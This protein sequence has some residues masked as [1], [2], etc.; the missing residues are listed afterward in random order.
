[1]EE[2]KLNYED[3][4]RK[5]TSDTH[6]QNG[7]PPYVY[8]KKVAEHLLNGKNII[9]SVP[10]GAGKTWA[11]IMPFL[12]AKNRTDINFPKKMIYSLPL[13]A[14]CNSISEDVNKAIE[15]TN[16]EGLSA[17]QTG[18]FS[19]DKYFE[20]DIIFSTIDQTLSNFLCFPLPLSQ[21]QANV[22][23]GALIGSYLVFDEFHLLDGDRSM[24]TTLGMLRMLGKLSRFCIMTATLSDDF[25]TKI[26][27][28][29]DDIEIVT[30]DGFDE[31]IAKI[32]SL[33]VPEN[34][35]S[36][37]EIEV[38]KGIIRAEKIKE[39][40]IDKTIVICNRVE[41]AQRVY[42]ELE[43][44]AKEK[45]INLIC[46][47][48]RFFDRHRKAAEKQLKVL[49]GKDVKDQKTNSILISTQVIEAGMDISCEVMHTEIAPINAL[50]QRLGRCARYTGEYGK[51]FV[52][53][54]LEEEEKAKID[55]KDF[56]NLSKED[57]TEIRKLKNLY[58]PYKKDLCIKTLEY[59]SQKK[60]QQLNEDITIE[61]VN[62][63]LK[64]E[65]KEIWEA[66]SDGYKMKEI[67][68]SW[69]TSV[70]KKFGAKNLYRELIRD[71]QSTEV[72]IID[73]RDFAVKMPFSLESVGIFKW[74]VIK[75]IKEIFE[76]YQHRFD[77]E[78]DT[79]WIVGVIRDKEDLF[80]DLDE[81]E[82]EYEFHP[83]KDIEAVKETHETLFLNKELFH[84]HH[85]IGFN[86]VGKGE[87]KSNFKDRQ[88]KEQ[89]I[90]AYR[91]DTFI[92]HTEGLLGAFEQ[93]FSKKKQFGKQQLDFVFNAFNERL[94]S[95]VDFEKLIQL[96]LILHDYG[97]LDDK[98]QNW[99]QTYQKALSEFE[100][101]PFTYQKNLTLGHTG[102]DSKEQ[103]EQLGE[104]YQNIIK[105]VEKSIKKK[106]KGGR[107]RH[108]GVG[109]LVIFDVLE[110]WLGS[111][112][113]WEKL[114]VPAA[115]A[116]ARHHGV[117][118]VSSPKF[119]VSD[120]NYQSINHL[121]EK[122]GFGNYNLSQKEKAEELED[123]TS[124]S[125]SSFL[126]YLFFVRILRLCDQKATDD[127]EKYLN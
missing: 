66:I 64:Q 120:H 27:G 42:L 9:L 94:K 35:S 73:N 12:Y 11:S 68:D 99:M 41:T 107:P 33:K 121:L 89:V 16:F 114:F 2:K 36:K 124:Y 61:L 13:R 19:E 48:S 83:L 72:I 44:W 58:L 126:M 70:E 15:N 110:D 111:D 53:D 43:Y 75:W 119:F 17:I 78:D 7:F 81:N 65:E 14:L 46:L 93:N 85:S 32:G 82:M 60:Y 101:S 112:K 10:T 38:V 59:L 108:S 25:M 118:N 55:V 104:Q 97:K 67:R 23:A 106:L 45:N 125:Q 54:V 26:K 69:R 29:L 122:Y 103:K 123:F 37:K 30:L 3:F 113:L 34:K 49:F 57:K 77:E 1:M 76:E 52:Y 74:S 28:A 90:H 40:H 80:L 62:E 95:K 63:I 31:D 39:N 79:F 86:K 84:Y 88:D 5:I 91:K 92:E 71:I 18:E 50:L 24:A 8:Q 96:I 98:W 4:Y 100:V 102:F 127:F 105:E 20:K 22:N 115:Y 116:I 109:A 47:H 56:K 21:R 87:E 51:V 117:S 6:N